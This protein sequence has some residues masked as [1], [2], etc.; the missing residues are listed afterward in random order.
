MHHFEVFILLYSK[1]VL[2]KDTE[3]LLW[4]YFMFSECLNGT[5]EKLIDITE[6]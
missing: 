1:C 5:L 3:M 6:L 4:L 2:H